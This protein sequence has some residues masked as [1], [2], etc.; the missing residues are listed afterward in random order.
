MGLKLIPL[1]P[2][3]HSSTL[4]H[5]ALY[6]CRFQFLFI[7]DIGVQMPVMLYRNSL[8]VQMTLQAITFSFTEMLQ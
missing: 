8:H 6:P 2:E 5:S 3:N 7:D 4:L 1:L